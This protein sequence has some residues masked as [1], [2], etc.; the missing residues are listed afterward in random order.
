MTS[1]Q[2]PMTEL[3]ATTALTGPEWMDQ[4]D[5]S[6]FFQRLAENQQHI[7]TNVVRSTVALTSMINPQGITLQ[8]QESASQAARAA[9]RAK[10]SAQQTQV[11]ATQASQVL[12]ASNDLQGVKTLVSML[13]DVQHRLATVEA[14][15]DEL[16]IKTSGNCCALQ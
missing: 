14:K 6:D 7:N 2:A 5:N 1:Q 10:E 11:A 15:L 12:Q 13:E 16:K 3:I 8:A 9:A 4:Y